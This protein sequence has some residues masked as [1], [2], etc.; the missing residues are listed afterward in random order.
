MDKVF[1]SAVILAITILT[2]MGTFERSGINGIDSSGPDTTVQDTLTVSE[3]KEQIIAVLPD[4]ASVPD[5][6][7][8]RKFRDVC[9]S[10]G[11]NM[12]ILIPD[13]E[14]A[15]SMPQVKPEDV[16]PGIFIPGFK[17]CL[18]GLKERKNRQ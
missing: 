6:L 9:N 1:S 4:S 8:F 17:D 14:I 3:Y 10:M 11:Y 5:S 7:I 18:N 12:P 13:E 16:D 15:S 2:V